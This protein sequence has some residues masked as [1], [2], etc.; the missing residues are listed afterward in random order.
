LDTSASPLTALQRDVLA[1]LG[2]VPGFYLSGGAALALVH[3]Q[4]R[5]SLDLDLF[6]EAADLVPRLVAEIEHVAAREGWTCRTL[7][8]YASFC[9]LAVSRDTETT[10]V[11]VVHDTATPLVDLARKPLALGVRTDD[12]D[13]LVVNKLCALLGRSDVKDLVDLYFLERA[14][15]DPLAWLD[16]ARQKDGAMDAATLAFVLKDVHTDPSSLLLLKP[17]T[18]PEL[19]AFRD[20]LVR[21]LAALAWPRA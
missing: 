2:G 7:Q 14:G 20:A 17:V 13:D 11:D 1:A 6:T 15:H 21:R 3:L 19:R 5:Q 4:H 12:L 18:E 8:R 16:R 10:L 9:R